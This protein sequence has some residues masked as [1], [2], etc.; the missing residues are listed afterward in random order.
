MIKEL[1][2]YYRNIRKYINLEKY[3]QG[4]TDSPM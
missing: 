1:Q 4:I 2:T 3:I